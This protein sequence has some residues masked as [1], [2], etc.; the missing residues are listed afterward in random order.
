MRLS[1]SVG[2]IVGRVIIKSIRK[3]IKKVRKTKSEVK[4]N[5]VV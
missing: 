1:Q 5:K 4:Y 3:K 2:V